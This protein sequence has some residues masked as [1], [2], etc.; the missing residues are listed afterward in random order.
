MLERAMGVGGLN[1]DT[2]R[3]QTIR[4]DEMRRYVLVHFQSRLDAF[5]EQIAANGPLDDRTM[6][7]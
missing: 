3:P 2:R 6:T 7:R 1:L 5:R 4:S